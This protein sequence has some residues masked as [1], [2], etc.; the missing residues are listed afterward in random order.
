MPQCPV[1]Q[2]GIAGEVT[3]QAGLVI[4]KIAV[5]IQAVGQQ[6][7]DPQQSRLP[8]C[9]AQLGGQM[10][11]QRFPPGGNGGDQVV[12]GII[13][14]HRLHHGIGQRQLPDGPLQLSG[15]ACQQA[16]RLRGQCHRYCLYIGRDRYLDKSGVH[17][18][19]SLLKNAA[20]R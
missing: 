12:I 20:N 2:R 10:L 19:T 16:G 4:P 3:A 18:V 8:Q 14:L 6:Q 9:H 5:G 17:R 7:A 15:T 1:K 11:R 13:A